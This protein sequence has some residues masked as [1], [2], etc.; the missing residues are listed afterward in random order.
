MA[1]KGGLVIDLSERVCPGRSSSLR[2]FVDDEVK[3]K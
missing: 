1:R 3:R 2:G